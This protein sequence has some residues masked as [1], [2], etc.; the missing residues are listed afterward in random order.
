VSNTDIL[1]G[2]YAAFASG[3]IPKGL[4]MFHDSIEWTDPAGHIYA[5]TS[6]GADAIVQNVFMPLG[7][8]WITISSNLR[9]SSARTT[10]W[11]RSDGCR[12]HTKA[13]GIALR[14][15]FVR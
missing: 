8:E 6:V 13:T 10:R 12:A 3:D 9:R 2:G 14:A 15:R 5:G 11:R 1:R 7:S 4:A